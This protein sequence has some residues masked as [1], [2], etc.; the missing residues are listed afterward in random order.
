MGIFR[1]EYWSG[2]PLPPP[3]DLPEP[4]IKP[5]S[6][7]SPALQA[8]SLPTE[9]SESGQSQGLRFKFGFKLSAYLNL[10]AQMVKNLPIMQEI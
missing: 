9:P 7:V 8:D 1:Q 6:P 4:G 2:L 10:M 3:G 5:V